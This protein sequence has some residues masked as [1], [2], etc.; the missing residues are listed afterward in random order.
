MRTPLRTHLSKVAPCSIHIKSLLHFRKE[1][2]PNKCVDNACVEAGNL[3]KPP[4]EFDLAADGD[5][6]FISSVELPW[7]QAQYEC[8]AR[9]GHLAELD[10]KVIRV[11]KFTLRPFTINL[12]YLRHP[13]IS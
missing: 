11:I 9:K 4:E 2:G 1:D 3:S 6:F 8:L 10:G 12:V 7:P 13:G 5:Y